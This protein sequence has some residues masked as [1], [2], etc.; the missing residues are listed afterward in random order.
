MTI[1]TIISITQHG[2]RNKHSTVSSLLLSQYIY[3][4][5]IEGKEDIDVIFIDFC[6]AFDA[7]NHNQL[8]MKIR[9]YGFSKFVL[10]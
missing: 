6:K 2:F 5:C 1:L 8:L 3:V 7:V 10:N 9:A 4:N